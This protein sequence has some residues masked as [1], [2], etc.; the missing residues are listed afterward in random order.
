MKPN[1]KILTVI[2]L[3]VGLTFNGL[4]AWK[5]VTVA[6]VVFFVAGSLLAAL[7]ALNAAFKILPPKDEAYIEALETL[8]LQHV[9]A[10]AAQKVI[11]Q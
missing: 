6:G 2:A 3:I 7:A 9:P 4:A 10:D 5:G 1:P 8:V 11:R